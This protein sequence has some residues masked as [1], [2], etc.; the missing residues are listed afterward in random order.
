MV[1]PG[2]LDVE[3]RLTKLQGIYAGTP[4]YQDTEVPLPW[5]INCYGAIAP[6]VALIEAVVVRWGLPPRLLAHAK[7]LFI[8]QWILALDRW[9]WHRLAII[10]AVA[11]FLLA[12]N[13]IL[14]AGFRIGSWGQIWCVAESLMGGLMALPFVISL[15]LIAAFCLFVVGCV[16]LG[17]NAIVAIAEA[18]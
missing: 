9:V 7:G 3:R 15:A 2:Q 13:A 16:Y 14:A 4:I 1:P 12:G 5:R 17:V 8:M 10:G 18:S 6:L 11:L